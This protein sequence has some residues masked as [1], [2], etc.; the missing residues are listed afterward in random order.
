QARQEAITHH[1]WIGLLVDDPRVG[2]GDNRARSGRQ[3]RG[4]RD[5]T[6][7][8]VAVTGGTQGGPWIKAEPAEGKDETAQQAEDQV[9]AR[10]RIDRAVAVVFAEPWTKDHR[11]GE[12]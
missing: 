2:H 10:N 6:D 11:A 12:R 1:R 5:H 3:H 4:Y 7:A 9:M 8:Q